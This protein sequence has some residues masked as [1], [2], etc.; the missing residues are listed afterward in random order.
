MKKIIFALMISISGF[1]QGFLIT[2]KN[3][4]NSIRAITVPNG[5]AWASI[6]FSDYGFNSVNVNSSGIVS[7]CSVTW[8]QGS[9]NSAVNGIY[10]IYGTTSCLG[11]PLISMIVN[12]V[13]LD[14]DYQALLTK[15]TALG[16]VAP[17]PINQGA[18]NNYIL[19][20]KAN[21]TWASKDII[22]VMM[23]DGDAVF[24]SLN[25]KN[26]NSNQLVTH[27]TITYT[28]RKGFTGDGTTGYL[29]TGY[30]S[31]TG[32]KF[33]QNE[34]GIAAYFYDNSPCFIGNVATGAR[35]T[36]QPIYSSTTIGNVNDNTNTLLG[37]SYIGGYYHAYRTISS[38]CNLAKN[39]GKVT[40][41]TSSTTVAR[42]NANIYL[43]ARNNAGTADV[44][45]TGT[46]SML[47][48]GASHNLQVD[49]EH[50]AW[51]NYLLATRI[52]PTFG[53]TA[54]IGIL[55]NDSFVRAS[56]GTAYS[57]V[58]TAT[59]ACN[60]T[61]LQEAGG[62]I[63]TYTNRCN[64]LYGQSSEN[65]RI[66][67]TVKLTSTPSGTTGGTGIIFSDFSGINGERSIIAKLDCTTGADAGKVSIGTFDGTTFA[68]VAIGSAISTIAA[69]DIF[70]FVLTK[71]IVSGNVSYTVTVTRVSD[72]A[73]S[74]CTYAALLGDSTGYFGMI[75]L[76]G[77]FDTSLFKPT[78]NDEK[79]HL[80]V[81]IGNSITHGYHA[82]T[83][84]NGWARNIVTDYQISAGSGDLTGDVLGQ[85]ATVT[86]K[87][88][89]LLD[90]NAKYYFLIIGGNDIGGVTTAQWQANLTAIANT[91]KNEGYKIIFITPP[92]RSTDLSIITTFT[93]TRF[94]ND[95]TIS[96]GWTATKNGA[97]TTL[98]PAYDAG[99]AIHPNDAGMAAFAAAIIAAL[100]TF[101]Y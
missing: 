55:I 97:A 56:L 22:Y 71:S 11:S 9:Y 69:N 25:W 12:V 93:K 86:G 21:G 20:L 84:V 83:L 35:V 90:Y 75:S 74:T 79:D 76:G 77:G 42:P 15:N 54:A 37:N 38:Q 46:V 92:A 43:I 28:S 73:S 26:P 4:P 10:T 64:Y 100:P 67:R 32:T 68:Q 70:Q 29:D 53:A 81:F 1:S 41:G 16:G 17:T 52:M 5:T 87:M 88:K 7:S 3:L 49:S 101:F 94:P 66:D 33:T 95:M 99:D 89:N 40:V 61:V 24:A 78:I 36:L 6:N 14:T 18:G 85:S 59:W 96:D 82:S 57:I 98:N 62:S 31:S 60:G 80:A 44:F 27:G 23:T 45:T 65:V 8:S 2:P 30:N 51:Q 47:W 63:G 39:G 50:L 19:T 34:G 13:T 58:G 91:L 48:V 72:N